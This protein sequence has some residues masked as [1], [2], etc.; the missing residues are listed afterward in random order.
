MQNQAYLN[1]LLILTCSA[2]WPIGRLFKI[3]GVFI[4]ILV[5]M[6]L[7]GLLT[8]ILANTCSA[9]IRPFI[10]LEII[11]GIALYI[12]DYK[13]LGFSQNKI[14]YLGV[15]ALGLLLA[16]FNDPIRVFIQDQTLLFNAHFSYYASQPA[17][18]LNAHYFSR[19]RIAQALPLEWGRYHF[20]NSSVQASA[21][22]LVLKPNLFSYYFAELGLAILVL[23]AMLEG[24]LLEFKLSLKTGI[25]AVLWLLLGFSA[26]ANSISWNLMTSGSFS[27]AA[28]FLIFLSLYKKDWSGTFLFILILGASAFR[29]MPIAFVGILLLLIFS[30]IWQKDQNFSQKLIGAIKTLMP[31]VGYYIYGAIFLVYGFV[32]MVFGTPGEGSR[33]QL[34]NVRLFFH[35]GWLYPLLSY[36][37]LGLLSHTF[38]KTGFSRFAVDGY[39]NTSLSNRLA[40]VLVLVILLILALVV[41]K[42]FCQLV[43]N[44]SYVWYGLPISLI[45]IIVLY[46]SQPSLKGLLLICLPYLILSL[47]L[48]YEVAKEKPHF[49]QALIIY[50]WL[51]AT[52]FALQF[53]P[54]GIEVKT[55]ILYIVCDVALWAI[56]G[57]FI[58]V[59]AKRKSQIITLAVLALISI[60]IFKFHLGHIL[61]IEPRV[62]VAIDRILDKNSAKNF[63]GDRGTCKF[64]FDDPMTV[65]AYS[66]TLGCSLEYNEQYKNFMSYGFIGEKK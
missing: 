23:L 1:F 4:P 37:L 6:G 16:I 13:H 55:P 62:P 25:L 41:I 12:K 46:F 29:L 19:L 8:A 30:F 27:V 22:G 54:L 59:W 50:F 49:N 57:I 32:T 28:I 42:Y 40:L 35:E 18:M 43:H 44:K 20:F 36:K 11:L 34:A 21:E 60:I 47:A 61:I 5:A 17:E 7:S 24:L 14:L 45:V 51:F 65:D 31:S 38:G 63:I 52:T 58:F 48:I 26:F 56:I 33:L 66:A 9:L 15:L 64:D 53:S 3:K 10:I 2:F 39:I